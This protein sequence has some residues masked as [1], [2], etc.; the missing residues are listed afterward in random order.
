[1]AEYT[2]VYNI[3][4]AMY[5]QATGKNDL[6]A[7]DSSSFVSVANTILATGYD[8]FMNA[9]STVL[10][11]SIF[12]F[13]PYNEKFRIIEADSQ[14]FGNHIRKISPLDDEAKE[15]VAYSLTDGYGVDQWIVNKPKVVQFNYYDKKIWSRW[16]SLPITQIDGAV[17]SE[18]EFAR[19]VSMV[20]GNLTNQIAQDREDAKRITF[21]NYMMGVYQDNAYSPNGRVINLLAEYNTETGNSYTTS[22]IYDEDNFTPF[23][24]WC[25]ARI[26]NVSDHLTERGYRYHKNITGINIP[27]HTPKEYQKFVLMS[28]FYRKVESTTLATTFHENLVKGFG[29]FEPINYLQSSK[30]GER[31]SISMSKYVSLADNGGIFTSEE[32]TYNITGFVGAIFDRDAMLVTTVDEQIRSTGVNARGLYENLWFHYAFRYCNDFTENY[33]M[34]II[35]DDDDSKKK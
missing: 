1:M 33:V 19:F 21:N 18:S 2:N 29:D 27:R 32:G 24:R 4:N 25:S 20:M 15:E 26:L 17:S 5:N 22:T 34:F 6:T 12:A 35:A 23:I 3:I 11:R 14:R 13:R 8:N 9:M 31:D 30:D 28:D 10:T 7:V 16:I